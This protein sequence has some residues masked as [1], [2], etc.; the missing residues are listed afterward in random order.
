MI[1]LLSSSFNDDVTIALNCSSFNRY[2]LTIGKILDTGIVWLMTKH[3]TWMCLVNLL[4]SNVVMP[5]IAVGGCNNRLGSCDDGDDVMLLVFISWIARSK[6]GMVS[7]KNKS[8]VFVIS[9]NLQNIYFKERIHVLNGNT[10]LFVRLEPVSEN[11]IWHVLTTL[12]TESNLI[13]L[14]YLGFFFW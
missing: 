11:T 8:I 4:R 13:L 2:F 5:W 1:L 14:K 9:R 12:P 10:H 3:G 6:L 7:S